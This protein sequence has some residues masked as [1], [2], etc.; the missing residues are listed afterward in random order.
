MV[1]TTQIIYPPHN[2]GEFYQLAW[3]PDSNKIAAASTRGGTA[4]QII[5][6]SD[7]QGMSPQEFPY[8]CQA[9]SVEGIS[10]SSQSDS[11][12]I[13]DYGNG[14]YAE[15]SVCLISPDGQNNYLTSGPDGITLFWPDDDTK[16][17][18]IIRGIETKLLSFD[19]T[20]QL[21]EQFDTHNLGKD[22]QI[23]PDEQWLSG[24]SGN[25]FLLLNLAQSKLLTHSIDIP[26]ELLPPAKSPNI[27]NS[28]HSWTADS[29]G[30]VFMAGENRTPNGVGIHHYGALYLLDIQSGEITKLTDEHWIKSYSVASVSN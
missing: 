20:G 26:G 6:I 13:W 27:L 1:N 15:A 10:W 18:V 17:H 8:N 16:L 22:I 24:L 14:R 9:G 2:P 21:L 23:S 28:F 25:Q 5:H 4:F 29:N 7:E 19:K 30:L 3:S 12:A 11:L